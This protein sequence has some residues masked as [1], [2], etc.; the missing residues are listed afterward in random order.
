MKRL[1]T[2]LPCLILL[3]SAALPAP[4][5]AIEFG[6]GYGRE[7]RGNKNLSQ[8]EVFAR[9]PLPFTWQLPFQVEMLSG[10]EIGGAMVR[11]RHS[12]NDAAARFS[13]MPQVIF[14]PHRNID[15]FAG[16]GTGIMVGNTQFTKHDLGGELLFAS[17]VGVQFSLGSNWNL[18]YFFFHQSNGG[19]YNHNASLN[20][21]QLELSFAF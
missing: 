16:L 11:E 20:M 19:I 13:V 5:A 1:H 3:L 14:R 6:I 9:Q 18:G 7:L 10:V 8:Y 4:A 2:S 12:D 17:K 15:F 21:H